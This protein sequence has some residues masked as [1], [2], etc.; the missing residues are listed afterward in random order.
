[1]YTFIVDK[2]RNVRFLEDETIA[3]QEDETTQV[4]LTI[5]TQKG[6][7]IFDNQDKTPEWNNYDSSKMT[8]DGITT[9]KDAGSYEATFTLNDTANYKWSDNTTVPKTV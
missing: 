2:R 3:N 7:I 5:P 1:M 6:S 9:G 8:I 4:S